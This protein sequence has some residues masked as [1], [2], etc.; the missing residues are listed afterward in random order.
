MSF[1][2]QLC[3]KDSHVLCSYVTERGFQVMYVCNWHTRSHTPH[4]HGNSECRR[5]PLPRSHCPAHCMK[6][7]ARRQK[8]PHC[9]STTNPKFLLAACHSKMPLWRLS[10]FCGAGTEVP[11]KIE[12]TPKWDV[13]MKF[14][15]SLCAIVRIK[16]G[17]YL[18]FSKLEAWRSPNV[19][20]L[21]QWANSCGCHSQWHVKYNEAPLISKE[22]LPLISGEVRFQCE[23]GM[24]LM[25]SVCYCAILKT[26]IL[27]LGVHLGYKSLWFWCWKPSIESSWLTV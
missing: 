24:A 19:N 1:H 15:F 16:D 27:I 3:P 17:K 25:S 21:R 23:L 4:I 10:L 22:K 7:Q 20:E 6:G 8:S 9:C 12:L 5:K 26:G 14:H 11:L 18:I 13:F 2:S